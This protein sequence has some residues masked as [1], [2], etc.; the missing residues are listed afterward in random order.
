MTDLSDFVILIISNCRPDDQKSLASILKCNYT[1]DW[2]IVLDNEDKTT[3]R[4]IQNYGRE[5]II[6]FDKKKYF[7]LSDKCDNFPSRNIALPARNACP[8]IARSLNKK[9]FYVLD[10]DIL[11]YS[12]KVYSAF[13]SIFLINLAGFPATITFGGTSLV[14]TLPAPTTELSPIVIPGNKIEPEPIHT[15]FPI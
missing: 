6:I 15:L 14:T 3:D 13:L 8:D 2:Y 4:Y 11:N 7:D 9:Y 1:G 12:I 5:K 10:D